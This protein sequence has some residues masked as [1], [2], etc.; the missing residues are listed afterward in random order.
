MFII[1]ASIDLS[2]IDKAKIIPG[3][4]G[5]SWYNISI[6]VKDEV[7]QYG[8]RVAISNGQTKEE[9]ESGMPKTYIGNGKVVF[10]GNDLPK[11]AKQASQKPTQSNKQEYDD[12]PF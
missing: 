6:L 12:L 5:K 3:K 10:E 8:N 4:D 1:S 11:T 2:K 9:R 7:D